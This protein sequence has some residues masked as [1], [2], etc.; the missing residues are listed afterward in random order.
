MSYRGAITET[1]DGKRVVIDGEYPSYGDPAGLPDEIIYKG[2]D[3][4]LYRGRQGSKGYDHYLWLT[5][6]TDEQLGNLNRYGIIKATDSV[7]FGEGP[8]Y[9]D[10]HQEAEDHVKE[11]AGW[12]NIQIKEHDV[13]NVLPDNERIKWYIQTEHGVLRNNGEIT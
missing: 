8:K 11:M 9:F 7:Y 3:G 4:T 2:T 6:L 5:P 10:T 13:G 1:E 12:S